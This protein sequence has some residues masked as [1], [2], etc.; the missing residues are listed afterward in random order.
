MKNKKALLTAVIVAAALT[1]A[2]AGR[3]GRDLSE[4]GQF[5]PYSYIASKLIEMPA[6]LSA[7]TGITY[8]I[9]SGV[10]GLFAEVRDSVLWDIMRILPDIY[11]GNG[12]H[13]RE[14]PGTYTL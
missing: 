14:A 7:F 11:P 6:H 8:W 2:A 12:G 1:G 9:F 5:A 13:E 4:R 10:S 3:I